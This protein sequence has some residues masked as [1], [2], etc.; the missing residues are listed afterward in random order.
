MQEL[1][2]SQRGLIH[3]QKQ[4]NTCFYI[5]SNSGSESLILP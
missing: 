2:R 3:S 4:Y 5:V 1:L